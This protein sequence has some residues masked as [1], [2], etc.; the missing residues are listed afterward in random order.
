MERIF[1]LDFVIDILEDTRDLG[2]APNLSRKYIKVAQGSWRSS[3]GIDHLH[4][5]AC[6]ERA[7]SPWHIYEQTENAN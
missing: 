7:N 2:L 1:T 3:F 6:E 5:L 4:L